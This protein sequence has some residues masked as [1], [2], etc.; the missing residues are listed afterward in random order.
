M[1][2]SEYL[3]LA[4]DNF[5]KFMKQERLSPRTIQA[6]CEVINKL[7]LVDSRLYRLSNVQ[8]QNFILESASA[9][10]QDLKINALKKFYHINHPK[11]RIR[12]FI[13]PRKD[14]KV[15]DVLTRQESLALIDSIT[16]I[17]QKA[18]ISGLYF[19][20]LRISE[21]LT[22]RYSDINRNEGIILIRQGKGRKDRVVPLNGEWLTYLAEYYHSM[23][24]KYIYT[25]NIFQPYSES[26]IRSIIKRHARQLGI[27][28]NVYPHLLRDSYATHL[29]EQEV[30]IRSIQSILGHQKMATTQKYVHV[31]KLHISAI[32]LKTE[33]F[34]A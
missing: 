23:K 4:I 3:T 15:I 9:S 19:H 24:Y 12:V 10:A 6:Y 16:N 14:K 30:S 20:G 5:V 34:I 33:R 31:S 11:K 1:N 2:K 22:L 7:S 21:I 25:G 8:I 18:I 28:K 32:K 13:R 29:H 27:T 26:S 17:K